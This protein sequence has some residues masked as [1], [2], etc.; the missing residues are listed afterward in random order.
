MI[1]RRKMWTAE[2]SPNMADNKLNFRSL[3]L[4]RT[5]PYFHA[6]KEMVQRKGRITYGSVFQ[7][8]FF[9]GF[10]GR[11]VVSPLILQLF[12]PGPRGDPNVPS[13]PLAFTYHSPCWARRRGETQHRSSETGNGEEKSLGEL[14]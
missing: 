6:G 5:R 13:P 9:C 3:Q 2:I 8:L 4:R 14:L 10:V 11:D 7:E 12:F 1:C